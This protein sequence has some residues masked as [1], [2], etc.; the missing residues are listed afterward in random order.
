LIAIHIKIGLPFHGRN[1]SRGK[2]R[3]GGVDPRQGRPE[4]R[5]PPIGTGSSYR[6]DARADQRPDR[7]VRTDARTDP[8]REG[9]NGPRADKQAERPAGGE[10][11]QKRRF[12]PGGG[13]QGGGGGGRNPVRRAS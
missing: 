5:N 10:P 7:V 12:R 1:E 2:P 4:H 11:R 13:G 3:E 6:P 8:R 9:G